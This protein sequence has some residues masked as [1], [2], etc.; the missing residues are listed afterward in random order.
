[1][2]ATQDEVDTAL[3]APVT[4]I[5]GELLDELTKG[6]MTQGGVEEVMS[7]YKKALIERMLGAEMSHLLGYSPGDAKPEDTSNW[8]IRP[9][10]SSCRG[11]SFSSKAASSGDR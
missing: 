3:T 10:T 1:M 11:T 2:Y 6:R 4:K 9:T 7:S 5:P 8:L